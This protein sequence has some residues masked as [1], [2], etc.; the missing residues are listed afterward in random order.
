ME[1]SEDERT[2]V[3]ALEDELRRGAER[4]A[5][6]LATARG[7]SARWMTARV[8]CFLIGLGGFAWI[9]LS[10]SEHPAAVILCLGGF[11]AFAAA[12]WRHVPIKR[13]IEA[14]ER[15]ADLVA[16]KLARL[17]H[18]VVGPSSP[19]RPDVPTEAPAPDQEQRGRQQARQRRQPIRRVLLEQLA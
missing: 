10:Q 6:R 3:A 18:Y 13:A 9:A 2:R 7:A 11:G 14:E 17:D 12:V 5:S 8:G 19:A 1:I 15:R 16:K 4:V